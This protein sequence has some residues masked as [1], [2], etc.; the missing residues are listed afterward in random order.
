MKIPS[1]QEN[2]F[3]VANIW[4][5]DKLCP[6]FKS[7]GLTANDITTLSLVFGLLSLFF[8][9]KYNVA[10]FAVTYY[11]SYMFDCMDGHYAR[12]YN[13]VSK[14]GD[15]YDHIKDV[16]V[17]IG[18]FTILIIRYK[19]PLKVSIF[20]LLMISHLGCQEKLYPHDESP[21]LSKSKLLCPGNAKNNI[22]FTR[23]FGCGTWTIV[24][25]LA[26]FYMKRNRI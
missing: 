22:K 20:T 25:I 3:D 9:W 15:Y 5:M 14:F 13:L 6:S 26:V 19:V 23:W 8:L 7:I 17:V 4:L 10:G 18:L 16:L 21:A 1:S 11:I 2:P 24:A 12:K